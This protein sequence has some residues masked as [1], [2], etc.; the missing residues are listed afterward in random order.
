MV[1]IGERVR[2]MLGV[3]EAFAAETRAKLEVL[4][5]MNAGLQAAAVKHGEAIPEGLYVYLLAS[6]SRLKKIR[7]LDERTLRAMQRA[8]DGDLT[9]ADVREL[10]PGPRL[11]DGVDW[12]EE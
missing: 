1:T 9:G 12:A 10:F 4:D 8:I 3:W 11:V 5:A 7:A 6:M 2:G